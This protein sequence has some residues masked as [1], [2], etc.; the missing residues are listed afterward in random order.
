M[1]VTEDAPAATSAAAEPQAPTP[2]TSGLAAILGSGDHKVVGRLWLVAAM[3]HLVLVGVVMTL[4]SAEGMDTTSIDIFGDSW[5]I[6][7]DTFRFLGGAFLFLAPL[8]LAVATSIVPLQVGAPTIAFPRA[9]AAAAWTNLMAGGLVVGAYGIEGGPGGTDVD[10]VRLFVVAFALVVIAQAVAWICVG[11]TVFALRAPGLSLRRTPPFAWSTLVAAGVWVV[12]LPALLA[13]LLLSYL[14]V[15]YGGIFGG[16]TTNIFA[17]VSWA[18]APPAVYAFAIP[19]LGLISSVV[20]VFAQTRHQQHR[21]ALGLIGA[22]GAL[23]VGAWT[24]PAFAGEDPL[25]WLYEGPWVAVCVAIVLPLLGLF[26]LWAL[27]IRQ[28]KVRLG[29]PLLFALASGLMLL[30]GVVAGAVQAIKPIETLVDGA[31]TPLYGTAWSTSLTGYV[32]LAAA[33]AML[34]GVVYWAPKL[35][36]SAFPEAAARLVAVLLLVGTVVACFP[37]L[38]AGLLGQPAGAG[39][40]PGDN[41]STIEALYTVTTVGDA[42]L[43]LAGLLFIV[44]VIK[45]AISD[46]SPGDDP[47]SGHTLEWATSSPPP[48]GNFASLPKITSEAPLYDARHRPEEADA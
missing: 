42:L 28:G 5:L 33:I 16:D 47:W 6:P 18:F 27:T 35:L 4:V 25:P 31:G 8:T 19:A 41:A 29:S 34:G 1:T 2:E 46:D 36:G 37:E 23:S 12:T 24:M 22:F 17:R 14:D 44:L 3:V 26:G 38:I 13:L 21:I 30:V 7:A 20:P 11:T 45:T 48:P 10:G 43:A 15:R 40:V 9:A 39:S 32:I